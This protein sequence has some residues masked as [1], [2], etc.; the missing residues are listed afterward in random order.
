MSAPVTTV[1]PVAEGPEM[2]PARSAFDWKSF[3]DKAGTVIGLLLIVVLFSALEPRTF[4]NW[5]NLQVILLQTAVVGTVAL[6]MTLVIV[7][8]GIDLS[9]GSNIA[10]VTVV[11]ALLLNKFHSPL[12]AIGGGVLAGAACGLLIGGLI[13]QLRLTPFIVT[14]GM[15]TAVRGVAQGLANNS[16]VNCDITWINNVLCVLP[17]EHKWMIFPPGVWILLVLAV[18]TSA[19][20]KF[21]R[22]G[23]H[24]FAIGSNENTAR[25]CGVNVEPTK[26]LIY[27]LGGAFAGVAGVLQFS[28]LGLGDSTT[29]VGYEL[30]AIAAV[31]IG[32][33]SL[34]GGQG[35]IFGTVVGALIMSTINNGGVKLSLP[36]WVQYILTG[37]IIVAAVALDKLRHRRS[38]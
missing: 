19:M 11:V 10:M 35:T 4:C 31:V 14:L 13:T 27:V 37:A 9:V 20:L 28:Y 21:T 8:G 12:I 26:I 32:G 15:L 30:S 18:L 3:L 25:L 5:N 36:N 24:I 16:S 34:S 2:V 29:A 22:F 7:S 6:G 23:R 1:N 33:A 17:P 38:G